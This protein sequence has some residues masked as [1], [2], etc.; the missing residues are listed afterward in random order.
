MRTKAELKTEPNPAPPPGIRVTSGRTKA[1]I[2]RIQ[3]TADG[4]IAFARGADGDYRALGPHPDFATAL[5]AIPDAPEPKAE[6]PRPRPKTVPKAAAPKA[7][8]PRPVQSDRAV[9][10]RSRAR[11]GTVSPKPERMARA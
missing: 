2:G 7:V 5:S 4:W 6:Q 10:V 9:A 8:A 11:S 1:E 3:R